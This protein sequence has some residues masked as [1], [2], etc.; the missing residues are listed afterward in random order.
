MDGADDG[1]DEAE[2]GADDGNDEAEASAEATAEDTIHPDEGWT[3]F[4]VRDP[5]MHA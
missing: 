2:G 4:E 1:N 5:V 3:A